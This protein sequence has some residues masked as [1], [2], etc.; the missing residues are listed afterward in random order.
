[1]KATHDWPKMLADLEGAGLT[2]YKIGVCLGVQVVQ[3]QRIK[4]GTE[5]KHSVGELLIALHDVMVTNVSS[6][7]S[8][9]ES[10]SL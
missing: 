10:T 5:P 1:M 9:K 4:S 3:I 6:C 2:P 7:P 8:T